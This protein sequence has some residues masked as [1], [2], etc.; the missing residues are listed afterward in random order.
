M[1]MYSHNCGLSLAVKDGEGTKIEKYYSKAIS[2]A[3]MAIVL[4][5]IQ[6]SVLIHQ[7]EFTPTPSVSP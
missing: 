7:M 6:I 2:Y 1:M 4:A 3:A 5:L